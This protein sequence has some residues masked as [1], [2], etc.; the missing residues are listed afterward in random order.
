VGDNAIS[1]QSTNIMECPKC[2]APMFYEHYF[3]LSSF[4]CIMCGKIIFPKNRK[5]KAIR[6]R[7]SLT[8]ICK[9]CNKTFTP[10]HI[11]R[12]YLCSECSSNG[13]RFYEKT[14]V[15]C[16]KVFKTKGNT[17]RFCPCCIDIFRKTELVEIRRRKLADNTGL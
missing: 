1:I 11:K 5:H 3:D 2:H 6:H 13:N 4:H 15:R 17:T 7:H 16:R 14:C 12:Q 9:S 10:Y 8:R